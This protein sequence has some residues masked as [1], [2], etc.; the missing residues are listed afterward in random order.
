MAV[1]EVGVA[2]SMQAS[3]GLGLA[4]APPSPGARA[5]W[6]GVRAVE[7]GRFTGRAPLAGTAGK[8]REVL[9]RQPERAA[10]RWCRRHRVVG[11][12]KERTRAGTDQVDP[13]AGAR[14]RVIC[15]GG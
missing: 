12:D 10:D 6:C 1:I 2:G 3:C 9:S 14:V 7:T 5:R 8:L 15:G 11:D 4:R 13:G